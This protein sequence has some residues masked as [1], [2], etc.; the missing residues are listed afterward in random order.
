[1]GARRIATV[2]VARSHPVRVT[3]D[4]HRMCAYRDDSIDAL[5]VT[6]GANSYGVGADAIHP[7]VTNFH[8]VE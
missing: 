3:G 4:A 1:M 2:I 7:H 5:G 6:Y 8:P